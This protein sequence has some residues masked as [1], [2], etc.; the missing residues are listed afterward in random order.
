MIVLLVLP[1]IILAIRQNSLTLLAL[2]SAFNPDKGTIAANANELKRQE[3]LNCRLDW[4]VAK[5]LSTDNNQVLYLDAFKCSAEF[6]HLASKYRPIDLELA[7]EATQLYPTAYDAWVWLGF[8]QE[9]AQPNSGLAA[10]QQAVSLNPQAGAVWCHIG[11]ISENLA[12]FSQAETAYLECCNNQDPG[13]A[14]CFGAGRMAEKTG[15]PN[16]ALQYYLRSRSP[17]AAE[18]AGELKK[19]ITP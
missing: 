11:Q 13:D 9:Y 16:Q 5:F 17:Q 1:G 12:L 7:Q 4:F 8:S 19:Q 10:Y 6:L 15:N 3:G 18:R 14:G 2:K